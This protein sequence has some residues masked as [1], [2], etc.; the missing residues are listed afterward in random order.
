MQLQFVRL[1]LLIIVIKDIFLRH[2]SKLLSF[3]FIIQEILVLE[4]FVMD[5][6]KRRAS[7][8]KER[9]DKGFILFLLGELIAKVF[10][11]DMHWDHDP[12]FLWNA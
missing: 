9:P 4:Q 3:R 10:S 5:H 8:E 11:H 1:V 6:F 12:L 7:I 2:V